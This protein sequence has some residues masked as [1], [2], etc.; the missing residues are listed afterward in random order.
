MTRSPARKPSPS[1]TGDFI[2]V[3]SNSE[4]L[5]LATPGVRKIDLGGKTV[6]PGFIDAHCHP[7]SAGVDMVVAVNCDLPVD[8]R[9]PGRSPRARR[10]NA[11]GPMGHRLEVRRH[12]RRRRPHAHACRPRR[13]RP[14]SSRRRDASRWSHHVLQF[15][16]LP[17]GRRRREDARPSGRQVRPR[18]RHRQIHRPRRRS[19][20]RARREKRHRSHH[21]RESR[22]RHQAHLQGDGS[23]RHHLR[24][25]RRRRRPKISAPTRTPAK[26]AI[27]S[28]ASTA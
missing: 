12:Q 25:R 13:R 11:A 5:N 28:S 3:G 15:R 8:R 2:A 14:R 19:G 4:V 22:R 26:P 1:R 18:S 24:R 16:R 27:F 7:C 21:A 23:R 17:R 20:S 6:L 10:E 9:D